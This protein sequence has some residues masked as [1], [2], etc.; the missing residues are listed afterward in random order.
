V[1][2]DALVAREDNRVVAARWVHEQVPAG[3]SI[4]SSGNLYGHPQL[5]PPDGR[6]RIYGY[7]RRAN[8][9]THRQRIG[10]APRERVV[11]DLPDWIVAQRSPLPYS[12][13]P[14][15]IAALIASDY[16]LVQTIRAGNLFD[17][18]NRYDIQD[19][20]YVPYA[21][22]RGVSRPGPNFEIYRRRDLT[23]ASR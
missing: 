9:F 10:G 4:H 3:S 5:E 20:F 21:G 19:G 18:R 15:R 2:F 14:D 7:D 17:P 1:Q 12:N 11:T 23:A 22:F 16:E 13:M 8:T 6:Y